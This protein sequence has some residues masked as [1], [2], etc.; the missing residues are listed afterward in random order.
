MPTTARKINAI[1]ETGVVQFDGEP[2]FPK[3]YLHTADPRSKEIK[4]YLI[5]MKVQSI[6]KEDVMHLAGGFN[7]EEERQKVL[8]IVYEEFRREYSSRIT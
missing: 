5:N 6:T 3:I 4:K 8:R 7:E 2:L 1:F